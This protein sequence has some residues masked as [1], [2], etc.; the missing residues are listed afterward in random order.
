V[1]EPLQTKSPKLSPSSPEANADVSKIFREAPRF[2][3]L[4]ESTLGASQPESAE[5]KLNAERAGLEA[6]AFA[7]IGNFRKMRLELGR[8]FI[9]LKNTRKHGDWERYYERT[10]GNSK[11]SFRSAERYMVRAKKADADSKI[12]S[13]TIFQPGMDAQA[14]EIRNTTEKAQAE[15]GDAPKPEL[16]Y[17]LALHLSAEQRDATIRLW[18]SPRRRRAEKEIIGVLNQLLIKFGRFKNEGADHDK[19]AR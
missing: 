6:E 4:G 10:F 15:I 16:V 1:T 2:P 14:R 19:E 11:V 7:I 3:R 17:R 13:L 8:I 18:K 5:D 12:D 9:R